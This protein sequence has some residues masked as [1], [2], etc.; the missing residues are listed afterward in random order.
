MRLHVSLSQFNIGIYSGFLFESSFIESR[1]FSIWSPGFL[2]S[3]PGISNAKSGYESVFFLES[4]FSWSQS[5]GFEVCSV[6]WSSRLCVFS[7]Y[8]YMCLIK[9]RHERV[10]M[11]KNVDSTVEQL[12]AAKDDLVKQV[13]ALVELGD[14]YLKKAKT[15]SNGSD[16]TKA[17]ALYNAA[18]VR[19]RRVHHE[20][21]EDEILG[22]I[23][24]T[25]R[26]FLYAFGNVGNVSADEVF[27]EIN[28]HKEFL[29]NRRSIFE[30]RVDEIDSS[31]NTNEK[32]DE[33]YEVI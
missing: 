11:D 22:R 23:A 5:P 15:S 24:E 10:Y 3:T 28:C 7:Q 31:F 25:Y 32:S 26:E 19:S 8:L 18:L 1:F 29:A 33:H 6:S 16:F 21:N 30:Q 12:K 14:W 17:N 13:P 2:L 27:L 4:G 9:Q 20:I